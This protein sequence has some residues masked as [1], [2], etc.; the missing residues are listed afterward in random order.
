MEQRA[1]GARA[2]EKGIEL[3]FS[4]GSTLPE[5]SL[6]QISRQLTFPPSTTRRLLKVMMTRRLI[7][8][9]ALTKLYRLGPGVL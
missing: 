2:L 7:Q 3:L 6:F 5:Q 4:F 9:D 1:P 8:Q